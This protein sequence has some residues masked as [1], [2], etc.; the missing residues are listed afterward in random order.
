MKAPE[1]DSSAS[2]KVFGGLITTIGRIIIS[3]FIPVIT[4]VVLWRVFLFLRD[5]EAPQLVII[6]VAILWGVG[7]VAL[8]FVVLNWFVEQL[9][10]EWGR[11]LQPFVFIG[12]AVAIMA[13]YLAIPVVRTLML[14]FKGALGQEWIGTGWGIFENYKFAFTDRIML[15]TFRNNLMW[16]IF[17]TALSVGFGL[18]VAV[19]ADR[20]KFESVYKAII[21][22]PMAISFVGAGVIWKFVYTYRGVGVGIQEIGLLNA[23]VLAFGGESQPWL[24]LPP[25]NNFF[26]III[27]VWLQTGFAMVVISSAIKGIPDELLEAA[28]IDGATE[29]QAF[30]GITIP[31]IKGTLLTVTTTIVIFSLKLFDIVRVMT[32]GNNGTNVIANEFYL[33]RFTYGNTGRASAIA[34]ILLIAVVPVIVYNLRQFNKDRRAF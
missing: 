23:I 29:V 15:E 27:M 7:G 11:K 8:L 30:F 3:L 10:G 2:G 28:R 26:L 16:M 18:L 1:K 12:P 6:L 19:L 17:G 9:P 34:I 31:Y 33:Q 22:M 13:W 14:S 32:G 25:W 4:F 21:F 5:S 24:S 20:S